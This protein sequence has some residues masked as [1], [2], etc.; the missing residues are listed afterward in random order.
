MGRSALLLLTTIKRD[1][2]FSSSTFYVSIGA[3]V[4]IDAVTGE[5]I[6][7]S[8]QVLRSIGVQLAENEQVRE[9]EIDSGKRIVVRM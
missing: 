2:N 3:V 9:G 7:R 4:S 8:S 1:D 6:F 5:T